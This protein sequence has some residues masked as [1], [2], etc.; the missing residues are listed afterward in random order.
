MIDKQSLVVKL[1]TDFYLGLNK[2]EFTYALSSECSTLN[3]L[4]AK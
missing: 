1:R 4:L 3:T 2:K